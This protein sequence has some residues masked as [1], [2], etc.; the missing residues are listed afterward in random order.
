M[1]A[2]IKPAPAIGATIIGAHSISSGTVGARSPIG[3]ELQHQAILEIEIVAWIGMSEICLVAV[4]IER[5]HET[6]GPEGEI[7]LVSP[8]DAAA[9]D[10]P[11]RRDIGFSE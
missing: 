1:G 10:D 6:F 11:K 4:G 2:G 8:F 9:S 7:G 5:H 3:P